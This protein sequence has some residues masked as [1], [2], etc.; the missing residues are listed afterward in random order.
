[1]STKPLPTSTTPNYGTIP[2]TTTTTTS[3]PTTSID[4]FITRATHHTQ[5]LIS[6]RRP[7]REL[8]SLSS[9]S[10][11]TSYSSAMSRLRR[12]L[13]YFRFNYSLIIL[14]ILFL[15]L[16]WHPISM[17]VFLAVFV[18]WVFLYLSRDDPI[19]V[20]HRSIDDR[21]VLLGLTIVT[22]LA[23]VFT[24]VGLN[25]LVSLVIG[26][27]VVGLH[28]AFRSVDDL[29]LDEDD[30]ADGNGLTGFVPGF[31]GQPLRPTYARV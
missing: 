4:S 22:I 20:F 23:L 15:S 7:W 30:V 10:L 9:L 1:M 27:F 21:F 3:T 25:V 17:I 14:S 18:L 2:T 29:F 19:V 31:E 11:P 24:N 5:T 28:A 12:N 8:L 26:F 16:L 13:N 6:H